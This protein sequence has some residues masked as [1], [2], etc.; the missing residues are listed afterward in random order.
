LQVE[1][2]QTLAPTKVKLKLKVQMVDGLG[3]ASDQLQ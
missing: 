1:L 2:L 3:I